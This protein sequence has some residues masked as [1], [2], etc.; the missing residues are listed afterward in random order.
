VTPSDRKTVT[1]GGILVILLLLLWWRF[2][3]SDHTLFVHDKD[4]T[5]DVE[6][7]PITNYNLPPLTI[8]NVGGP[9]DWM[10]TT[11]LGCGCDAGLWKQPVEIA[12]AT[13]LP[14]SY[15]V[16]RYVTNNVYSAGPT[17]DFPEF[18][19][20]PPPTWWYAVVPGPYMSSQKYYANKQVIVTS[21]GDRFG[22]GKGQG[23]GVG[24]GYYTEYTKTG[25][26][27]YYNG[28]RF[29]HDP[30]KDV[31]G[32]QPVQTYAYGTG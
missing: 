5:I 14:Q 1:V 9:W 10:Q 3:R 23:L 20:P 31:M 32:A 18:R 27:L 17:Y 26:D 13:A 16:Y 21:T 12:P 22:T 6:T 2:G 29:V 4:T 28:K 30:S 24:Y 7:G 15:P 19:A 8:P 11:D 25:S